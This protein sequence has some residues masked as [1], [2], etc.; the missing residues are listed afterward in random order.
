MVA[1]KCW[2]GS[3][4]CVISVVVS[5]DCPLALREGVCSLC[6]PI[7]ATRSLTSPSP[8][9]GYERQRE[10]LRI[11]LLYCSADP[12]VASQS[13]SSLPFSFLCNVQDV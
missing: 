2:L 11:S 1:L 3:N 9:P 4:T 10:N 5:A 13:G 6:V 12:A 7:D 8:G